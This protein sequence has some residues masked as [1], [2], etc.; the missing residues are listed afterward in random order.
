[1]MSDNP[2]HPGTITSDQPQ[3]FQQALAQHRGLEAEIIGYQLL[4]TSRSILIHDMARYNQ[5][6]DGITWSYNP[7]EDR[8]IRISLR[9]KQLHGLDAWQTAT[10]KVGKGIYGLSEYSTKEVVRPGEDQDGQGYERQLFRQV[11]DPQSRR[12]EPEQAVARFLFQKDANE[13]FEAT[14][15]GDDPQALAIAQAIEKEYRRQ[16]GAVVTSRFRYVLERSV[17]QLQPV[18]FQR[19][20]AKNLFVLPKHGKFAEGLAKL[21]ELVDQNFRDPEASS[22]DPSEIQVI[23]FYGP[24]KAIVQNLIV[25]RTTETIAKLLEQSQALKERWQALSEADREVQAKDIT[26]QQAE[27]K[28]AVDEA[29][30]RFVAYQEQLTDARADLEVNLMAAEAALKTILFED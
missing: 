25:R 6:V 26:R 5:L 3:N 11:R 18:R 7:D 20:N 9:L 14:L 30:E 2:G 19:G 27:L 1:M 23:P 24:Q 16:L 29:N 8:F 10:S 12:R 4:I 15:L 28:K 22:A 17:N 13:P 21:V